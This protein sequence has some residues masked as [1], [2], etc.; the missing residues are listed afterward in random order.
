MNMYE[1]KHTVSAVIIIISGFKT[2]MKNVLFIY[3]TIILRLKGKFFQKKKKETHLLTH[4]TYSF[5]IEYKGLVVFHKTNLYKEL[6]HKH[7]LYN[8]YTI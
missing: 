6:L 3:R 2:Q 5:F 8:L 1:C 4:Q 7:S